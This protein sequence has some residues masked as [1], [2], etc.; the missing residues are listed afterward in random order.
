M[1]E[2]HQNIVECCGKKQANI[3]ILLKIVIMAKL[4]GY[5]E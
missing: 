4:T 5:V 2:I 3:Q 1:N